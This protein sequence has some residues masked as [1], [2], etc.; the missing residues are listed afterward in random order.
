MTSNF[1]P[2]HTYSSNSPIVLE[3]ISH[4]PIGGRMKDIPSRL[5]HDSYVRVGEKKTGGPNLRLLRLDPDRPANTVT[6]YIFN[7]FAHPY[8][9]R[10]ITPREAAR[11]QQFPDSHDFAGPITSVQLQIGNAVPVGL[12][13]AV[14]HHVEQRLV[15]KHANANLKA[16]SLFSGAGGMDLGFE[17]YFHIESANELV[18]AFAQTLR[19]N[20][21]ST[22]VVNESLAHLAGSDLARDQ[23]DLIFGGP[24]CQPFSAAGKHR[25]VDDP[26]GGL[27]KE[28][29]R[30][31]ADLEPRYFVMENVPGLVSNAKGGAL[32]FILEQASKIGYTAEYHVLKA[33]DYGVPQL[34]NRL[35]VI[36]RRDPKEAELGR[37]VPSHASPGF[38]GDL[39]LPPCATV[40]DAFVGL[41]VP[42]PRDSKGS[43]S[44]STS[45]G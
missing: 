33:T 30:I 2:L 16:V 28:Y 39:L 20:F 44:M 9:D 21:S 10:Y 6:A 4:L 43:R 42:R 23:I 37:P 5:W 35:F 27:V 11:L 19:N 8:E 14:A 7:K 13:Q 1:D 18:P 38:Q 45:L 17:K 36:G 31:V 25:G 41:G 32:R 29:L 26:R 34:R 24:P 15:A 3:R 40:R 22:K 12:A